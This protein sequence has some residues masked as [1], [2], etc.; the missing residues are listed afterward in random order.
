MH[1]MMLHLRSPRTGIVS[2]PPARQSKYNAAN[3]LIAERSSNDVADR[4]SPGRICSRRREYTL[5][6]EAAYGCEA[7]R[8][9]R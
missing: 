7:A 8:Y 6:A 1:V 4:F 9:F 2:R 3:R 5:V